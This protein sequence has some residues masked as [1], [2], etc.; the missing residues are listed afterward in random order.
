LASISRLQHLQKLNLVLP[1]GAPTD[2]LPRVPSSVK[3]FNL[4]ASEYGGSHQTM[5]LQQIPQLQH[6]QSLHLKN[7]LG[8]DAASL[9]N[10]KQLLCLQLAQVK[11]DA[12]VLGHLLHLQQLV[13]EDCNT[14]ATAA[15]AL[16]AIGQL[17]QLQVLTVS[18]LARSD[19]PY[20]CLLEEATVSEMSALTASSHLQHLKVNCFK[21]GYVCALPHGA[22]AHMFPPG[23]LLQQLL[24]LQFG[25]GEFGN[26]DCGGCL[27]S[28]DLRHI[29]S[30]C[31]N[32]QS[33]H[34]KHAIKKNQTWDALLQLHDCRSL[35]VGGTWDEFDNAA[36]AVVAQ[37]TQLTHLS[38]LCNKGIN[39]I[40]LQLTKLTSLQRLELKPVTRFVD[41]DDMTALEMDVVVMLSGD[42]NARKYPTVVLT[43]KV[44][45]HPACIYPGG[46]CHC[47]LAKMSM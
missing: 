3:D 17:S 37:M 1:Y 33:V 22:A 8:F 45:D 38:C 10:M 19:K 34:L 5:L 2:F 21:Y 47:C 6:L 42:D 46:Q 11:L 20:A 7:V 24:F 44:S 4:E 26:D 14:E 23:R 39:S 29:A 27:S 28:E 36:A 16:A 35:S 41:D 12:G 13:L 25:P 43:C 31:P 30:S 9:V 40:G 32:L 18:H 15:V